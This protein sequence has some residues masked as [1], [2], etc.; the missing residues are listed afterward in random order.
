[1]NNIVYK[2][3]DKNI[4]EKYIIFIILKYYQQLKFLDV[5]LDLKKISKNTTI[6]CNIC[7]FDDNEYTIQQ[8]IPYHTNFFDIKYKVLHNCILC[9][10]CNNN[11]IIQWDPYFGGG[12][13][14]DCKFDN[15]C[16]CCFAIGYDYGNNICAQPCF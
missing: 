13:C 5:L 11:Y 3:L 14:Q 7:N 8:I 2:Y 12:V 15:Q 6:Y 1:M 4:N 9:D 16:E 10:F